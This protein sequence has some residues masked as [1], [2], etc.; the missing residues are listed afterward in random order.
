VK[1]NCTPTSLQARDPGTDV[2]VTIE[3][4]SRISEAVTPPTPYNGPGRDERLNAR[5]P[6]F[7][8]EQ[9]VKPSRLRHAVLGCADL[10][11]ARKFFCEGIGLKISDE[12]RDLGVFLRYSTDHHNL[13]LQSAPLNFLHHT[14]WQVDDVNDI[15]RGATHM[16]ED[17]PL[18]ICRRTLPL[19]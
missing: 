5:A 2:V 3:L 13:L 8:R 16:L 12:V 15:G 18:S 1:V 4:A 14:S 10:S 17:R 11:S 9:P 6:L 7:Q 19:R